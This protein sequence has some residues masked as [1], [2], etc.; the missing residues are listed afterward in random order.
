[1]KKLLAHDTH[2]KVVE[3]S[4]YAQGVFFAHNATSLVVLAL[5]GLFF[6]PSADDAVGAPCYF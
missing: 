3:H 1:M 5:T 6:N 4:F 2:I